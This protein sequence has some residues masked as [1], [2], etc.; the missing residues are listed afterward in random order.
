V[1]KR[2]G[3]VGSATMVQKALKEVA[4]DAHGVGPVM[5]CGRSAPVERVRSALLDAKWSNTSAVESY[6][7]RRLRPEDRGQL[8][9][10]S[11]VVYGGEVTHTLDDATRADLEVVGGTERPLLVVLEGVELPMDGSVEAARVRGVEPE[12]ILAVKR[13]HFPERRVL[14]AIAAK[15]GT[16]GP[17][18]A[19]RLPALRPYIVESI[20]ETASRRNAVIA[21]AIWIPGA[22]MPLLTAVEMRMMLQI[23]V[24]YGIEV[25]A[26]RAVEL[27]GLL[28][29]GFGLRAAARELLDV[30][31]VAGWVVKGAVAYS[32][33]R[34][35]G[36]AA[37]EYFERGAVADVSKLRT[38][39]DRLRS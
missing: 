2:L 18:L 24:C 20:I 39:A 7:I 19:S 32:G 34:A 8:G 23:G 16:S 15:A 9:R 4:D 14:R 3:A 5:L 6:A 26:D 29:A 10:A 37:V 33:T 21:A 25:G 22:D 13:G 36:R 30:V 35:L 38:F 27:L 11:V 1:S 28:G 31:P 17:A 12:S